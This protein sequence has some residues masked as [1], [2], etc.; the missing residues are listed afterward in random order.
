MSD[1]IETNNYENNIELNSLV[2]NSFVPFSYSGM[3]SVSRGQIKEYIKNP[4]IYNKQLRIL[5]QQFYN[6]NGMYA[7]VIDYCIDIPTLSYITTVSRYA[8][9]SIKKRK[10]KY[11]KFMERIN[12]K[13]TTRDIL[14]NLFLNGMYVGYLRD[15]SKKENDVNDKNTFDCA[16]RRLEGLTIDDNFQI[17]P[18]P[19]D[20]CRIRGM[21]NGVN[22]A[23]FDMSYFDKWEGNG[24]IAQI[25]SFPKEFIQAYSKYKKDASYRWFT[26]DYKKTIALKCKSRKEEPYG[27]PL[28]LSAFL[29]IKKAE[30]YE[31]NQCAIIDELASS[32]YTLVL[33][34]GDDKSGKA[35]SL[36]NEQQAKLRQAFE[37]AVRANTTGTGSK[38]S[39]V[40]LPPKTKMERMSKDA[41][42]LKDT[43]SE[44]NASNIARS[45]GFAGGALNPSS[46]GGAS[47][48][49]LSVNIDLVWSQVF[50]YVD[51]IANEYTRIANNYFNVKKVD[52]FTKISYLPISALNKDAMFDKMKE[53]YGLINGNRSHVIAST[54]ISID[55]YLAC[56]EQEDEED[57]EKLFKPHITAYTNSG[58]NADN[59]DGEDGRPKKDE[60]ELTE[61][62]QITR[63]LNSN[64]QVKPSSNK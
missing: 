27:R 48:S 19:L 8:K 54:G 10:P 52:D 42:L 30:D 29:D 22:V 32:I 7:N 15:T 60:D 1:N 51:E 28:G 50:Q 20:Y 53:L 3:S 43:L 37:G 55:E 16:V 18:L 57:W 38:I 33:P 44:E 31:D 40:T 5:S 34:E 64:E 63:N 47:Y 62:G 26:L 6:T 36:N 41:S 4:M 25:K 61:S 35:C 46:Q 49:S 39:T 58:K 56:M 24:L 13:S 45:L 17:E 2:T 14:F 23:Q 11:D 21:V 12:H 59:N 9:Q